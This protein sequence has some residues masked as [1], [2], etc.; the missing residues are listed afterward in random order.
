MNQLSA[1][2]KG[3]I[4]ALLLIVT[5]LL[6]YYV[7]DLPDN[8]NSQYLLLSLFIVGV[9]WVIISTKNSAITFTDYFTE[10]FKAFIVVALL[11]TVYTF[12]FQKLNPQILENGIK[13]NNELILKQGNKTL[14]EIK[15][16]AEKLRNIFM[17]MM[18][19]ITAL[20][21][22]F[23]GCMISAIMGGIYSQKK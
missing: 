21:F 17:P 15:E 13:E 3:I 8:G 12:V 19:M 11:M 16:N 9:I 4:I 6:S 5:S 1:T 10:G 14:A 2:T 22:L 23:L 18:L 20:K 7:F